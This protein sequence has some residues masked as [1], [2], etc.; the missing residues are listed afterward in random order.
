MGALHSRRYISWQSTLVLIVAVGLLSVRPSD[1]NDMDRPQLCQLTLAEP[2]TPPM[3]ALTPAQLRPPV[4]PPETH[5][6]AS[7]SNE[8][9]APPREQEMKQL[10]SVLKALANPKTSGSTLATLG[11]GRPFSL[12]RYSVLLNDVRAIVLHLQARELRSRLATFDGNK[13]ENTAWL[14]GRLGIMETCAPARFDDRGGTVAFDHAVN[15]VSKSRR[16]LQPLLFQS[17]SQEETGPQKGAPGR[18]QPIPSG[19][20]K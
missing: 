1:A 17:A 18:L 12:A 5:G 19:S 16:E 4:R 3:P 15:L 20:H 2:I 9:L 8:L 14:D 13:T 7:L 11:E 6:S 10:G